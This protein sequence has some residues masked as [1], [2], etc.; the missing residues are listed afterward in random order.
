M[1]E[2]N[3]QFFDEHAYSASDFVESN[4]NTMKDGILP[5]TDFFKVLPA[6]NMTIR[7]TS[8]RGWVQGHAFSSDSALSFTLDSADGV[9]DRVDTVIIR[10]DL[11]T[12]NEKIECKVVK[13]ALGGIAAA[14]VRNGTYYDLVIA[15]I[16]VAHGTT[17]ITSAMITDKRGDGN[18]CGWSGAISA[19]Q[20]NFDEKVDKTYCDDT[21]T[22]KATTAALQV[23]LSDGTIKTNA[24]ALQSKA[25][26]ATAPTAGQMLQFNGTQYAPTTCGYVSGVYTGNE[27]VPTASGNDN[28]ISTGQK[29]TLG[30]RPRALFIY[31][32]NTSGTTSFIPMPVIDTPNFT[33]NSH[34]QGGIMTE[35]IAP[36]ISVS[37]MSGLYWDEDLFTLESDGFTVR[38]KKLVIYIS[39]PNEYGY[40]NNNMTNCKYRYIAFR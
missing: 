38:N 18:L 27:A 3:S 34:V 2:I 16:A 39:T 37:G 7:V 15:Q 17:A 5:N 1:S 11:T 33:E 12:D 31:V 28:G 21:F 26:S 4:K 23:G 14:P 32:S 25:I 22:T 36:S 24:K 6:S 9:L 10:L 8:G 20:F 30:F 19:E 40:I 35:G 13:G 29:I